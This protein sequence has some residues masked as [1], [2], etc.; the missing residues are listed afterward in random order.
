MNK[1]FLSL[2]MTVGLTLSMEATAAAVTP[3]DLSRLSNIEWSNVMTD[4][5]DGPVVYD[6]NFDPGGDFE[7]VSRWSPQGI[8]ATYRTVQAELVGYRTL[9]LSRSVWRHGRQRYWSFPE[10]EPV[11]RRYAE[12]RTPAAIKFAVNGTVLTYEQGTVSPDLAAAL[13]NAPAG[14]MT[15]RLVWTD[16]SFTDVAIGRG[17]VAA[18]KT[19]FAPSPPPKPTVQ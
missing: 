4:P 19:I 8:Q 7:F 5:F 13:A 12:D 16:G 3:L 15:I 2:L 17:T 6:K 18:W 10:Q 9:W 11:Y 1:R 14:N